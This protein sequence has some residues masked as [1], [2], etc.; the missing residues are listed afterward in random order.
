MFFSDFQRSLRVLACAL[1]ALLWP[2]FDRAACADDFFEKRIRPILVA[3]CVKCHGEEEQEG[4]LRLDSRLALLRGGESGPAAVP[5]KADSSLIIKAVLQTGEL[6]MPPDGK[7]QPSEINALKRWIRDGLKWPKSGG[8]L[9]AQSKFSITKKDK[10]H[11]SFQPI[12]KP[13]L[14][15]LIGDTWSRNAVDRFIGRKLRSVK[16]KPAKSASKL[17]LIRRV[18][19]GLTGLPP[20]AAQVKRFVSDPK[21]DAYERLVERLLASPQYG[22][23]W[24]RHW[25]DVVR[26][27]DSRDARHTG[28]RYDVNE[29]WRY[30]DWVVRAFNQDLPYDEFIKLQVA[31]DCLNGVDASS[32]VATGMLVIGEWGSGDADAKKMYTDIVDDQI[33]VVSQAFLSLSITCARC[34]DHKF[35]P[36][37]TRDYYS[38]A[39]IFFSTQIAT[40]RT[41]APLMRRDLAAPALVADREAKRQRLAQLGEQETKLRASLVSQLLPSTERYL[42][43]LAQLTRERNV[44]AKIAKVA[45][46]NRLDKLILTQWWQ[47]YR[48]LANQNVGGPLLTVQGKDFGAPG[49][50]AWKSKQTQPLFLINTTDKTVMVPGTMSARSVAVHPRPTTGVG[51]AWQSPIAGSV[52]VTG[53][54]AD[55][56]NC[57]NGVEWSLELVKNNV[58]SRVTGGQFSVNGKQK[59]RA[60]DSIVIGRGDYIRLAVFPRG[61]YACDLT[62][63]QLVLRESA[64]KRRVWNLCK[65]ISSN[66]E[67]GNPHQDSFGNPHVWHF[68]NFE[69]RVRPLPI[70]N[71]ATKSFVEWVELI[72]ASKSLAQAQLRRRANAIQR[73][74]ISNP[75][76]PTRQFLLSAKSPFYLAINQS[77]SLLV[78]ES[79]RV[80]LRKLAVIRREQ[81]QLKTAVAQR[82]PQVLAA[83]EGGVPKTVHAGFNDARVHI[84]GSYRRLGAKVPR[85]V[86]KIFGNQS[87]RVSGSGRAQ[88]AHWIASKKNPLT[89]RVMVNRIWL[90]HFGRGIVRTPGDFGTQGRKPTHPQLL[91]Y[92]AWR[93]MHSGWS[94]KDIHRQLVLSATYQQSSRSTASIRQDAEN[95]LWGRMEIRRLDCEEIRDTILAAADTLDLRMS[96]PSIA[97]Y[98]Q[99]YSRAVFNVPN[100]NSFR[101]TLYLMSIRSEKTKGPFVLDA[102]DP[103]RIVHQRPVTTTSPQALFI[104]NNPGVRQLVATLARRVQAAAKSDE[105]RVNATYAFLFA[106]D[107]TKDE[108]RLNLRFLRNLRTLKRRK[109]SVWQAYCHALLCT[110]EL[111]YLD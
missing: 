11:W 5:N 108:L 58:V 24:G 102:A 62:Q 35:D 77:A 86:P 53:F 52:S 107:P 22:E 15:S 105:A 14:P 28:Q 109:L 10:A 87:F 31:G 67:Q 59:I 75:N 81:S 104:L 106:R 76:D 60:A 37:S 21:P 42:L 101:R 80:Q 7:L 64:G 65:D 78:P 4:N 2:T 26:Y 91:D 89:A 18:T 50:F 79:S 41:D 69:S 38:L 94:I 46:K 49:V 70:P 32:M 45:Q 19:Y 54:V 56:H 82:Y 51:V 85:G 36:I 6:K 66:P 98:P 33:H 72:R 55:A 9:R 44:E 8:K 57:G 74:A 110:N 43:G 27:C 25:L 100:Y 84:R 48:R 83:R 93:L 111:I 103:D 63:I 12:H 3:K 29:A 13:T 16:L 99:G 39:G 20:T 90:H 34:H 88:L 73:R 95:R 61:S 92:L 96:G 47:L 40:P 30:R 68:V 17:T 23:R 1:C 71:T 97:R